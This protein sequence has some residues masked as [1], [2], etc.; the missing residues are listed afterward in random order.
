[1]SCAY[2]LSENVKC[3]CGG[4]ARGINGAFAECTCAAVN[5]RRMALVFFSRSSGGILLLSSAAAFSRSCKRNKINEDKNRSAT[6]ILLMLCRRRRPPPPQK[7]GARRQTSGRGYPLKS[8][9]YIR[10]RLLVVHREH[11]GNGLPD[12]TNLAQLRRGT[13]V[14]LRHTQSRQLLLQFLQL[15]LELRLRLRPQLMRLYFRHCLLWWVLVGF[16]LIKLNGLAVV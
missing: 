12:H 1:M 3:T 11:P 7:A 16:G 8:V 15:A 5:R 14:D 9:A 10:F 4:P 13:V 6:S 2:E